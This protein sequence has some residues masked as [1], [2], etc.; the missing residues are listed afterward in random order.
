MSLQVT[1]GLAV[2]IIPDPNHEFLMSSKDVAFG[3]GVSEGNVRNQLYRNKEEFS[4]GKHFGTAVCFPNS[5]LKSVHNKVFWTKHGIVR[6]GFF[7]KSERARMFRDWAEDLVLQKMEQKRLPEM[8]SSLK[9][10]L[11]LSA[12]INDRRLFPYR[13]LLRHLGYSSGGSAYERRYRYPNHFVEIGKKLYVTEELA[14]VIVL[15]WQ[16]YTLR[17]KVAEM[18]P[19]LPFNFGTPLELKG[20]VK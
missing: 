4:E 19:V 17:N 11:K 7:I 13:E 10:L 12:K 2:A 9:P 6:L 16:V 8:A 18:Q 3:Y 5:D 15:N 1:D 20:G 14:R